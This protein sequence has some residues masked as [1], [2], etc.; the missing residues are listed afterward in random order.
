MG[1]Q[2][3]Q[4]HFSKFEKQFLNFQLQSDEYS[5]TCICTK[6][7][8]SLN[9]RHISLIYGGRKNLFELKK[10]LLIQKSFL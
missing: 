4:L 10:V 5:D 3:I 1:F 7:T 8:V 6:K 2:K 9:Q